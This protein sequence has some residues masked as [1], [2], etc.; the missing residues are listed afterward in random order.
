MSVIKTKMASAVPFRLGV[1]CSCVDCANF[2]VY[3]GVCCDNSGAI[4]DSASVA[5]ISFTYRI[6]SANIDLTCGG[7]F[8]LLI[9][10]V[11]P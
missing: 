6:H 11:F 7:S 9:S 3:I 1:L 10:L 4:V 8:A 5:S 2:I